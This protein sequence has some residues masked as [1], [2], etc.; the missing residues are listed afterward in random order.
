MAKAK[1]KVKQHF[2]HQG[3]QYKP[4]DDFE[5]EDHEIANL[6]QQGHVEHPQ[7][8]Q[9]QQAGQQPGG[10]TQPQGG[11]KTDPSKQQGH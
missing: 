6:A 1:A 10:Q 5:G 8:Q 11:Q 2:T 3:K 4:G 7:G 9:A